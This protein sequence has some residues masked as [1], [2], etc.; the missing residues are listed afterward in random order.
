MIIFSLIVALFGIDNTL[1]T[2]TVA[3][4]ATAQAYKYEYLYTPMPIG[5]AITATT[6]MGRIY[7]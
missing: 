4:T 3:A 6:E 7:Q 1:P 2:A 5:T